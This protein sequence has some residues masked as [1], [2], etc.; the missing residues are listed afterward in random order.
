MREEKGE[1]GVAVILPAF[2]SSRFLR[3]AL[4][5]IF[6][7]SLPAS[8]IIVVD[9]GSP[10]DEE[11]VVAPFLDRVLYVRK[12]NGGPASA[13]NLGV[14]MT[15]S[16]LIA[17]L[18]ADD[19]W[20]PQK[21][22]TQVAFL[23]E[24]PDALLVGADAWEFGEGVPL[25]RWSRTGGRQGIP[26]LDLG[27]LVLGNGLP[28]LTVTVRRESFE[29]VG[30][31]NEDPR[32]IAVEDYDLWLR[33]AELGPL[34]YL[35]EPLARYRRRGASLSGTKRFLEGVSRA[36]DLLIQRNPERPELLSLTRHRRAGLLLDY[37]RELQGQG[38]W[39]E[40]FAVILKS[41]GLVP[42]DLKAWK[43]FG[44]GCLYRFHGKRNSGNS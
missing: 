12:E 23:Q 34:G 20:E 8:E 2:K 36:L 15:R 41:L 5:S 19:L 40:S 29:R 11:S 27:S 39:R 22:R 26:K 10:E 4:N 17:F 13:R 7:Q 6:S 18:D 1:S 24:H 25:R 42:S 33:L 9:D 32:L 43:L 28:T 14:A 37:A 35:D 31:F 3:D 38:S 16:P 44:R 30:G 21:L